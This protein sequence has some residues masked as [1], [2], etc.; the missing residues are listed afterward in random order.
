MNDKLLDLASQAFQATPAPEMLGEPRQGRKLANE[1]LGF[2]G[3]MKLVTYSHLASSDALSGCLS[4]E[5]T[6]E[7]GCMKPLVC[8]ACPVLVT[9][10][11]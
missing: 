5:F 6:H 10:R 9:L 4:F 7:L 3:N 2:Q 8:L 1:W 11:M